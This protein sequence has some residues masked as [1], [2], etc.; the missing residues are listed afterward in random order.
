MDRQ[1]A[2]RSP[3]EAAEDGK[4]EEKSAGCVIA[5]GHA[6]LM[7]EPAPQLHRAGW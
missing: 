2:H 1:A 6:A 3:G 5:S 4:H 7:P